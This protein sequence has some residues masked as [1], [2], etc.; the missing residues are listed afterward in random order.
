M[1]PLT[2]K[3]KKNYK[4]STNK[5]KLLFMQILL[6]VIIDEKIKLSAFIKNHLH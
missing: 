4:L 3:K 2:K 6:P 5:F 1:Y